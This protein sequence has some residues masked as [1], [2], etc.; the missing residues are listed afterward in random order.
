M[1]IIEA[2]DVELMIGAKA[3]KRGNHSVRTFFLK[4]ADLEDL[5]EQQHEN[6]EVAKALHFLKECL[7]AFE[8]E[9]NLV[10]EVWKELLQSPSG[11]ENSGDPEGPKGDESNAARKSFDN[12]D[13]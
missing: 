2:S 13:E 9:K 3:P 5:I 11:S 10:P 12:E 6:E 7:H 4:P 8:K 1:N